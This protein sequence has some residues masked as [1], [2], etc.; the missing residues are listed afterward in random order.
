MLKYI[1]GGI[2]VLTAILSLIVVR[3]YVKDRSANRFTNIELMNV[4][5]FGAMLYI[6]RI[7]FHLHITQALGLVL[8]AFI[9][10]IPYCAVL[11][12][13]IRLIP[14]VSAI[15]LM[16]LI[17]GVIGSLLHYGPNPVLLVYY[18][19][20][21]FSLEM[22]FYI[23]GNYARTFTNAVIGAALLGIIGGL[24]QLGVALPLFWHMYIPL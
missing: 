11:V 20:T 23:T 12:I 16:I 10:F 1:F 24:Y 4:A 13:G 14:K 5:L 17:G 7:P 8:N 2:L 22:Y 19:L 18:L 21:G 15:I 3:L 6:V 9:M